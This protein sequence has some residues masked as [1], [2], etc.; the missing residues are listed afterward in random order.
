[1]CP[2]NICKKLAQKIDGVDEER[3][4]VDSKVKKNSTEVSSICEERFWF[5]SFYFNNIHLDLEVF[6]RVQ[7]LSFVLKKKDKGPV[8]EDHWAEGQ[9][10]AGSEEGEGV[11]WRHV[12]SSAGRQGQRVRGL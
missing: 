4:D 1:M 9:E 11:C 7:R 10:E 2:Q 12:G 3:Y 8:S 5:L 6:L